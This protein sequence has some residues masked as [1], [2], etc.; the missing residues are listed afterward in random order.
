MYI[1][2]YLYICNSAIFFLILKQENYLNYLCI[3]Y[4][5]YSC[6]HELLKFWAPGYDL[7]YQ[8]VYIIDTT[9]YWCRLK[10]K[11]IK[12]NILTF[13]SSLFRI[14]SETESQSF[15]TRIVLQNCLIQPLTWQMI[16]QAQLLA[17]V[18]QPV[19]AKLEPES[20]SATYQFIALS[21]IL[22]AGF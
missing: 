22:C 13:L 4:I 15:R 19:V 12:L 2:V 6:V 8:L 11:I 10:W 14:R 18:V 1:Y 3:I 21:T 7:M 9:W 5:Y 17:T 16:K 20:R